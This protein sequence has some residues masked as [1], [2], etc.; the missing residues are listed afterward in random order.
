MSRGEVTLITLKYPGCKRKIEDLE[1]DSVS[2]Q[3]RGNWLKSTTAG[4]TRNFLKL[5][6]R[7]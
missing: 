6:N 3:Q 1:G 7:F 4:E 2:E 5:L